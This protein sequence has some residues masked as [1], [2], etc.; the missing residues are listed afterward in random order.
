[1]TWRPG[2]HMLCRMKPK[3]DKRQNKK[4]RHVSN[5]GEGIGPVKCTEKETRPVSNIKEGTGPESNTG[6]G[7]G[8]V[9]STEKKAMLVGNAKEATGPVSNICGENR[10]CD[11]HCGGTLRNIG[12]KGL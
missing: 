4:H 7:T 2:W 11:Q 12:N 8:L 1:M 9:K 5:S 3:Q 10:N 6:E